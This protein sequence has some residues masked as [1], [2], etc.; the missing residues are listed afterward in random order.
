VIFSVT[1]NLEADEEHDTR[2]AVTSTINTTAT[3][4]LD[5]PAG[6]ERPELFVHGYSSQSI[7]L[8]WRRPN[9]FLTID[10]PEKID[11]KM[12]ISSKL[13][14]Y[15][16]LVNGQTRE[17][18]ESNLERFVLTNC[19]SSKIFNLQLVAHTRLDASR[20]DLEVNIGKRSTTTHGVSVIFRLFNKWKIQTE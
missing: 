5:I 9:T 2:K 18:L 8:L 15:D 14:S 10:H 7:H 17:S 19:Q 3:V 13:L 1:T 20:T 16:L 11:H 6:C 4:R 12:K